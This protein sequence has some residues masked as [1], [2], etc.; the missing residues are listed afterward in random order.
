MK[1]TLQQ[2]LFNDIHD[3][4]LFQKANNHAM[5]YVENAFERNVYPTTKALDDL[6]VFDEPLN[7][8]NDDAHN[9]L[10]MLNQ[11]GSPATLPQI[12]GRYFGFVNGSVIPAALAAKNLSIFW[13]QNTAMQVMSPLSAK[14]ELVVQNWLIDLLGLP[15]E[16]VAGFVSGTSMANFCA[17]AAAK[18]K[19]FSQWVWYRQY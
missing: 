7:V 18:Y 4:S 6:Q 5:D 15:K 11:Y 16:T 13:D 17:L 14:L 3:H 10:N 2:K 8:E 12:A 1:T 19:I 9:I